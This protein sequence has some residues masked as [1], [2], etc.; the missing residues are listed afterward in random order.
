MSIVAL[1]KVTIIGHFDDKL[2]V[3]ND[4]QRLGCLHLECLDP[5]T[6]SGSKSAPSLIS[7]EAR[8]A[9]RYLKDCPVQRRKFRRNKPFDAAEIQRKALA[10]QKRMRELQ[11]QRDFLV[12]RIKGVR[13]WGDFEYP[14][15]GEMDGLRLWFYLV[16]HHLMEDVSETGLTWEVIHR[17]N[18][19]CY[20]VVVSKTE[21]DQMP[22]GRTLI[23]EK[24]LSAL[25]E[26][27][28]EV[29][30]GI[31]QAQAER[32]SLTRWT[33]LFEQ[34]LSDLEARANR[35]MAA[36]WTLD[37]EPL[38]ALQ[39]WTPLTAVP[40]IR[41]Y[42]RGRGMVFQAEDPHPGETPPTLLENDPRLAVG[43]SLV[44]FYMTPGYRL[45][46]PSKVVLFSFTLFF[47]MILSD[48]G[49]G[50]VLAL[51]LLL[52]RKKLR[53]SAGARRFRVLL[54]LLSSATIVW[55]LIVGSY[56]G[57]APAKGSILAQFKILD[58]N[59]MDSMMF[60][61]ILVGAAHVILAN[62]MDAWRRRPSLSALAPVGWVITILAALCLFFAQSETSPAWLS[63]LGSAGARSR[64][65]HGARIRRS[66]PRGFWKKGRRRFHLP[67][68][69]HQRLRRCPELPSP[70]RARPRQRLA[71]HGL[72]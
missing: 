48:A 10:N 68:P 65:R 58:M 53:S 36:G 40:E 13:P 2:D 62:I 41:E 7:Q 71:R 67:R 59:D 14:P 70:L 51:G 55:G 4:L 50:L 16:P 28:D 38:F 42:V 32:E 72:Q 3:L 11:D 49:Y 24:S 9:L 30:H 34:R 66:G 5:G 44:G 21:P 52:F 37:E 63:T 29:D 27:L 15:I 57:L 18:R 25:E 46:D 39:G 6:E 33:T 31:D 12:E 47:A 56:F 19:H 1:Q 64:S 20:V 43:E 26:Q 61:S 8:D 17:D 69:S 23:G 35:R 60:L 54:W 22:V 45:W